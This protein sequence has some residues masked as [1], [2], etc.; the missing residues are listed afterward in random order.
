MDIAIAGG[1]PR[2]AISEIWGVNNVGK[3]AILV[4]AAIECQK[5]YGENA[6]IAFLCTEPFDKKYVKNLGLKIAFSDE[7]IE[8]EERAAGRKFNPDEIAYL[9]EQVGTIVINVNS[10]AEQLLEIALDLVGLFQIIGIDSIGALTSTAEAE[11]NVGE[12]V[13]GGI[14]RPMKQFVNKFYMMNSNTSIIGINQVV[15]NTKRMNDYSPEFKPPGGNAL[16]HGKFIS[17]FMRRGGKIKKTIDGKE[18]VIGHTVSWEDSKQKGGGHDG[19]TGEFPFYKGE[20]GYC[21]GPDKCQDLV[22]ECVLVN[23]IE[24][25]GAW[26]AYNG[27]KIGQ[28]I[29][30]AADFIRQRPELFDQLRRECFVQNEIKCVF[31]EA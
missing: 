29:D 16:K 31:K 30:A 28:G 21:L 25:S 18:V 7:E 1:F 6:C 2:G 19:H 12:N 4:Y 14:S 22:K 10:S 27:E 8:E 3:N 9:K 15:D 20:Y 11:K 24:K 17:I 26:F 13:F 23:I 5:I